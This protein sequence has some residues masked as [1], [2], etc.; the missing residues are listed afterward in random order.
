[1]NVPHGVCSVLVFGATGTDG[2]VPS[3][4]GGVLLSVMSSFIFA[5]LLDHPSVTLVLNQ[6]SEVNYSLKLTKCLTFASVSLFNDSPQLKIKQKDCINI[7]L[8]TADTC[9]FKQL[10]K[11]PL[12]P[13][14]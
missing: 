6:S 3:G 13:K 10:L 9:R 8:C 4:L 12:I 14:V 7:F 5:F 1:M 2:S 11:A